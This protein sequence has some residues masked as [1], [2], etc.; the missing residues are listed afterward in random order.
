MTYNRQSGHIT[1]QWQK[2]VV[3]QATAGLL[4]QFSS[5]RFDVKGHHRSNVATKDG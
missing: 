5:D 2:A 1:G 4:D 3:F